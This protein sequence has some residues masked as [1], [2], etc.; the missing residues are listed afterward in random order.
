MNNNAAIGTLKRRRSLRINQND[1]TQLKRTKTNVDQQPIRP[2]L[3]I[4]SQYEQQPKN[5]TGFAVLP[6]N[7]STVICEFTD[8]YEKKVRPLNMTVIA[9]QLINTL[10]D[11]PIS[12]FQCFVNYAKPNA[13]FDRKQLLDELTLSGLAR[14]EELR[15]VDSQG[16]TPMHILAALAPFHII[17][18]VFSVFQTQSNEDGRIFFNKYQ[19]NYD[20]YTAYDFA[21]SRAKSSSEKEIALLFYKFKTTKVSFFN[22]IYLLGS[23][24]VS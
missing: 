14:C 16:H 24:Q 8:S 3:L 11:S 17:S 20:G 12:I 13:L 23:L 15:F 10:S 1:D 6:Y 9:E 22:Q 4:P 7:N 21:R 2:P 19:K 18:E 5:A